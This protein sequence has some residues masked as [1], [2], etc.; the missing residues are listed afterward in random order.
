MMPRSMPTEH[1]ASEILARVVET[2]A[3]CRSY[4]EDGEEQTVFIT[5]A[6]PWDRRTTQK[7][8]HT[9]FV[10]G[11]RLLFECR[12]ARVGP[13]SE[14]HRCA[15]WTDA[16]GAHAFNSMGLVRK[17]FESMGGAL[18][19]LS[20]VSGGVS[21]FASRLLLAETEARSPL[22]DPDSARLVGDEDVDNVSCHRIE[23]VRLGK[24]PVTVWVE[25]QSLL[26]RRINSALVFSE[27][28]IRAQEKQLREYV[29]KLP[30]DHPERAVLEKGEAMRATRPH[31]A[32][33]TEMTVHRRAAVNVEIDESVFEFTPPM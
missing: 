31:Q 4:R 3:S 24:Q 12:E 6:F 32:F 14:W 10:R 7:K 2:Y 21:W 25:R 9:A 16:S 28:T 26:V 8:F 20:A 17:D 19:S 30:A 15:A 5:G 11:E 13:E 33:R 22:P 23:G 27:D 29:A 1:S 18:G